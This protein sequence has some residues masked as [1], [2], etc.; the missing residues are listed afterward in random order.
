MAID[1]SG[2]LAKSLDAYLKNVSSTGTGVD[3]SQVAN[4]INNYLSSD[5]QLKARADLDAPTNGIYKRFGEFDKVTGK[6]EVVTEGVWTGGS[7]SLTAFYTSSVQSAADSGRYYYDIYNEVTSSTTAEVQFAV[8][9]GHRTGGGWRSLTESDTSTLPTKAIFYQYKNMLLDPTD[10]YFTFTSSSTAGTHDSSQIYVINLNRARFKEKMDPGNISIKLSGSE[11]AI[12]L[13]DDSG[14]KIDNTAGRA[15][16]V[17]NI[18]SG[19]L[20]PGQPSASIASNYATNGQGFGLFYPDVGIV[21]LNPTALASELSAL[22]PV[23]TTAS[24]AYNHY[25]LFDALKIGGDFEARRVENVST[26]HYF[27]RVRNREFNFSN[28]PSYITG[29]NGQFLN[30]SFET[31]P[32]TYITTIGLYNDANELLAV[33]KVSQPL[34]KSYDREALIRVKLDF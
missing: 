11:G 28:N 24:D 30:S 32:K 4:I 31:D 17:F 6:V 13:I 10:N 34:V 15:G 16:R 33:A 21:V 12:T 2:Q 25:K 5:E 7:G 8:A 20:N 19:T 26:A 29:S 3:T 9:Y 1:R 22:D 18:V 14:Q 27:V 23:V